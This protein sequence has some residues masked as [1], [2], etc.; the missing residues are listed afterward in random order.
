MEATSRRS[1]LRILTIVPVW[2]VSVIGAI[3]V[4]LTV[5]GDRYLVWLP[6]V[7]GASILVTFI[8]QLATREKDG[9]VDRTTMSLSGSLVILGVATAIF[10]V[11]AL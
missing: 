9:L 2:I 8:L 3:V 4:G 7:L 5:T 11:G 6:L 1:R 10:A